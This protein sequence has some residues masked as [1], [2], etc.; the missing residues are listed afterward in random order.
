MTAIAEAFVTLRPDTKGFA[1]EA[2]SG[3]AGA[4]GPI[5]VAAAAGMAVVGGAI[6]ATAVKGVQA[7]ASFERQM[8]EVFTLLPGISGEAMDAM[9][10]QV[11]QFSRDFGTLPEEVVPSLYQ[12]L[13]AGV[14]QDNVFN[15]LETA[16]KAA[17]AGV[18]ELE[19]AVD[20]ISSVV[21]AY[22]ADVTDATEVSD[23]MFTAV[24]LGKTDFDQLSQSLFQVVPTAASLGVTFEEVAASL[25]TI[26][27]QGTP[28]TVASTQ[29]RQMFVELSKD[30]GALASTFNE[31]ANESF[32]DFV[33]GGGNVQGALQL[34]EDHAAETG[35]GLADLFGSVEAG[36]AALSLTGQATD[37]FAAALEAMGTSAGATD[38]A[39]EQM[40][41]GM[42]RAMEKIRAGWEVLKIHIG[43]ALMPA[44]Q[45]FAD[46]I[47]ENMP[48]I[49]EKVTTFFNGIGLVAE[50]LAV[51]FFG[52][53]VEIT[54]HLGGVN[55][56][57]NGSKH[58]TELAARGMST[59]LD[60]SKSAFQTLA[61]FVRDDFQPALESFR[62]WW[63]AGGG[64]R[65]F[66][67]MGSVIDFIGREIEG[68]NQALRVF[69]DLWRS[70]PFTNNGPA[71]SGGT[72]GAEERHSGGIFG[73]G[74][75]T[76]DLLAKPLGHN[77]GFAVL[78]H[79][80]EVLTR[81]DPR[82]ARFAGGGGVQLHGDINVINPAPADPGES[83][84]RA[85]ERMTLLGI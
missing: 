14:P 16:Q 78:E 19:T 1:S 54:D 21:N 60:D 77:E 44:V 10:D 76:R 56:A 80:E 15:F 38:D 32:A 8:N 73:S 79:G 41:Q 33:E 37:T 4:F 81:D 66:D 17:I 69:Q 35:V 9:S 47:L 72:W 42:S 24:R 62:E 46:W 29:L 67:A 45:A 48:M 61:D 13:S 83:V 7:F 85:I 55:E 12:A 27:A 36:Q 68:V 52:A 84:A 20:G 49:E 6:T 70:L 50:A 75:M 43:E 71:I 39:F 5:G 31:I 2:R 18:T 30:G 64:Q 51:A 40:D 82:H 3:I 57:L 23:A 59:E 26:T 11:L 22:G 65:V 28:T 58:A 25:A 34:L 63:D 53:K 74:G